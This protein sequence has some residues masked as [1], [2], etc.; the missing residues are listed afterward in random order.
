MSVCGKRDQGGQICELG[1]I[2]VASP[3]VGIIIGDSLSDCLL[4]VDTDS[5]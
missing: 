3:L 1:P 5:A 2:T 4:S